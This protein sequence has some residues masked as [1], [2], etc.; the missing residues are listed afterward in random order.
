MILLK[1]DVIHAIVGEG[2]PVNTCLV[3][4]VDDGVI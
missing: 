4:F 3:V 2:G 1:I